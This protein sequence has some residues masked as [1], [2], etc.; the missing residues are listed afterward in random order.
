MSDDGASGGRPP[1]S[2]PTGRTDRRSPE[3][4]VVT[5]TVRL[6]VPFAVTFGLFTMFHGTG[7]VGGGFQGGVVVAAALV[8]VA[9]SF[10]V[11]Q[12]GRW[13]DAGALTVAAVAGVVV[14]AVVA[15]APLAFGGRVLEIGVL[16]VPKAVVYAIEL[17]ELG[18]GATVAGTVVV[19]LLSLAEG[20]R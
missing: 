1:R 20:S 13:I 10:G 15:F 17:V 9:F 16:P 18:I 19:L 8:A 7:S 12:T 2:E 3:T 6:V 5:A 4:P 11:D 14:F